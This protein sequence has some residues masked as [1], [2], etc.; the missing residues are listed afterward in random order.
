LT[1]ELK[2]EKD[3]ISG[4]LLTPQNEQQISSSEIK[5]GKLTLKLGWGPA[6]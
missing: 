2:L 6:R 4:R 3:K 5:D 1:L